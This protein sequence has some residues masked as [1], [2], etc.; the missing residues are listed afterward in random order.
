MTIK[1]WFKRQRSIRDEIVIAK[2]REV[3]NRRI[4]AFVTSPFGAKL[5]IVLGCVLVLSFIV[6][7][8]YLRD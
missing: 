3:R 8:L 7:L 5:L 4:K 2:K 1:K 6:L